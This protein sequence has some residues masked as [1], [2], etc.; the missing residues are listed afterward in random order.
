M[1]ALDVCPFIPVQG[2]T[3]E[4]C[5]QCARD[6]GRML[7]EMLGV[8]VFLY[9]LAAEKGPH[10]VTLPQIRAGEYEAMAHKVSPQSFSVSIDEMQRMILNIVSIN[11]RDRAGGAGSLRSD[12]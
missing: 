9:G 5:V 2:V 11:G 10:R 8:S 12:E 4:D 7:A 3:V 6:F 1:G